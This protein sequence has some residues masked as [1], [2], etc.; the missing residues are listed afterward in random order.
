MPSSHSRRDGAVLTGWLPDP[1][2]SRGAAGLDGTTVS[3]DNGTAEGPAADLSALWTSLEP[4][5]PPMT[6]QQVTHEPDEHAYQTVSWL[7]GFL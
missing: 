7:P 2:L 4:P 3:T 5:A 6:D 1:R